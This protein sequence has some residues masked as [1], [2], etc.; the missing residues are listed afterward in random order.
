ML[1]K[2]M[3]VKTSLEMACTCKGHEYVGSLH[4]LTFGGA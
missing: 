3:D 2:I 4:G 1:I